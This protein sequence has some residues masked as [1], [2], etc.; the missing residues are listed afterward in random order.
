MDPIENIFK[1][2]TLR[3]YKAQGSQLVSFFIPEGSLKPTVMGFIRS[4]VSQTEKI[5]TKVIKNNVSA[6]L[7]RVNKWI[8]GYYEESHEGLAIFSGTVTKGNTDVDVL[9]HVFFANRMFLYKC[10]NVF[11]LD[12]LEESLNSSETFG[13]VVI[14]RGECTYGYFNGREVR[15]VNTVESDVRGKHRAG[16]QSSQRYERGIEHSLEDFLHSMGD[17]IVQDF[18]RR[19]ITRSFLGGPILT[20]EQFHDKKYLKSLYPFEGVINLNCSGIRGL[21]E[22]AKKAIPL[23]ESSEYEKNNHY[24]ERFLDNFEGNDN[25]GYG[26]KGLLRELNMRRVNSIL[27]DI[28]NTFEISTGMCSICNK[29]TYYESHTRGEC[30]ICEGPLSDT[31]VLKLNAVLLALK[32]KINF[33]LMLLERSSEYSR[34]LTDSFSSCIYILERS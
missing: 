4:E 3:S 24:F 9:E 32:D 25:Y 29:R 13:L 16:G 6:A 20:K 27:I 26:L 15:M 28:E 10:A 34:A 14:E 5:K 7:Q 22:L 2:A 33:E 12:P 31:H 17:E 8:E 23:I 1:L 19:K 18:L 21:N 11:F 30:Y